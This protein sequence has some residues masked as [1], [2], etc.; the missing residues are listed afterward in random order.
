[1]SAAFFKQVQ[2]R[3]VSGKERARED[4]F[5]PPDDH[6]RQVSEQQTQ[7][8][9]TL[10]PS[11]ERGVTTAVSTPHDKVLAELLSQRPGPSTDRPGTASEIPEAVSGRNEAETNYRPQSP[12]RNLLHDPF[13]GSLIGLSIQDNGDHAQNGRADFEARKE[14]LWSHMG[15]I[16]DI[17]TQ[18]ANM[19]VAMENIGLGHQADQ[20]SVERVHSTT[21]SE[22]EKWEDAVE[23][24][25][26][27]VK[28]RDAREQEFTKLANKFQ[29][30]KEATDNIMTKVL[31][32]II[33][34]NSIRVLI[35]LPV[36]R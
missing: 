10:R 24:E 23:G 6:S 12:G 26:D 7:L 9:P 22:G 34:C 4:P 29:G 3:L 13:A 11:L 36:A 27:E 18:I 17:Q 2:D 32:A 31:V 21:A 15:D 35:K 25:D 14:D 1:M 33:Y 16:R 20:L 5:P 28:E 8:P 30:R 19:H